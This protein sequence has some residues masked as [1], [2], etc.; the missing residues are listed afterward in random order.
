MKAD[1]R[2]FFEL[3]HSGAK[4]PTKAHAF[5]ACYD[6]YAPDSVSVPAFSTAVIDLGIAIELSPGWEAQIRG[7]SGL[8]SRGFVVHNGTID[9]LY[10]ENLKVIVHNLSSEDFH[11]SRGDRIAQIKVGR[12]W[13]IEWSLGYVRPTERGGLGSTGS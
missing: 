9:T 3:R 10:R 1:T 2:I 6:L 11:F 4:A 8:A 12:V 7:R 5:D 13:E